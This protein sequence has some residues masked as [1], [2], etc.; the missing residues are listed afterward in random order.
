M[1]RIS[2]QPQVTLSLLRS[3]SLKFQPLVLYHME[4]VQYERNTRER[5]TVASS[6]NEITDQLGNRVVQ[7]GGITVVYTDRPH[8]FQ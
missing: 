8:S 1:D 4:D 3:N 7:W 5:T 2:A 6:L